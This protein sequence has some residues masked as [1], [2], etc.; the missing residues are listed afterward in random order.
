MADIPMAVHQV[1]ALTGAKKSDVFAHCMGSAMLGMALLG[2][3]SSHEAFAQLRRDLPNR[4]RRLVMSQVAPAVIF[5]PANLFRAYTMRYLKHYLPLE[6]YE[7]RPSGTPGMVDQLIDLVLSTLPYPEEEFDRE[8]PL[9]PPWRRT[10]WVGTRHR[11]DALYGRD[12][13]VNNLPAKVLDYI[14]DQFGPLSIDTVSQAIHFA[15]FRTITNT[16]GFN[17]YVTPESLRAKFRFPIL[18]VHGRE[19]GLISAQT[20]KHFRKALRDCDARFE[21]ARAFRAEWYESGHQDLLIGS[22]AAAMFNDVN[23]FLRETGS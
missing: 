10:P 6:D 9:W 15:R 4:I 11:M 1:C 14:D 3:E 5:T 22:P 18:H 16:R 20:P 21:S 19:N 2:S 17:D 7:F 12:F 8:N 13:N 23:E